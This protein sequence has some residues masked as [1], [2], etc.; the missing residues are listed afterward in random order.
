MNS[1]VNLGSVKM[2]SFVFICGGKKWRNTFYAGLK[3]YIYNYTKN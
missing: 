1:F 2:P 3:N